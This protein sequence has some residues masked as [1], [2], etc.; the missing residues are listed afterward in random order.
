M[1]DSRAPGSPLHH[2]C[3]GYRGTTKFEESKV[4]WV[5]HSAG[6]CP[7]PPLLKRRLRTMYF[8]QRVDKPSP[9]CGFCV[10][11][12]AAKLLEIP[13]R[14]LVTTSFS[15]VRWGASDT[16][17][18]LCCRDCAC[19]PGLFV[20]PVLFCGGW[21]PVPQHPASRDDLQIPW[22]T[23]IGWDSPPASLQCCFGHWL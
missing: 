14:G 12:F 20:I 19:R 17:R 6:H 4:T 1:W 8:C 13:S 10:L 15:H 3:R 16:R 5:S 11:C 18:R 23:A 9:S 21:T 22:A 7:N 2:P